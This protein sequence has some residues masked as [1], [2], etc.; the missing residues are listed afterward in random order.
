MTSDANGWLVVDDAKA[1]IA[2][3]WRPDGRVAG[4]RVRAPDLGTRRR[5][6][7]ETSG[8]GNQDQ[9]AH[10]CTVSMVRHGGKYGAA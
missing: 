9:E 5:I 1:L 4:W 10:A 6:G 3:A 8:Q 2:V 7:V